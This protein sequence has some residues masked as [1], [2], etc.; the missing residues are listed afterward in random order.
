M[1]I[2]LVPNII[3]RYRRGFVS[4]DVGTTVLECISLYHKSGIFN[5]PRKKNWMTTST[6]N[7]I[8]TATLRIK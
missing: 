6:N 4:T 2:Y 1:R 3:Y 5:E 7:I 8:L